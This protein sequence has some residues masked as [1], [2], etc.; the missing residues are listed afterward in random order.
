MT[1]TALHALLQSFPLAL[2]HHVLLFLAWGSTT[3]AFLFVFKHTQFPYCRSR[4]ASG[5]L[6]PGPTLRYIAPFSWRMPLAGEE[7]SVPTS[8]ITLLRIFSIQQHRE[9]VR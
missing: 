6:R 2:L 9:R 3:T 8:L 4:C 7:T 5:A 1:V